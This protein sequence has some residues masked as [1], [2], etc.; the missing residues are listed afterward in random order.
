MGLRV[1]LDL[2]KVTTMR[3]LGDHHVPSPECSLCI[4]LPPSVRSVQAF[5]QHLRDSEWGGALPSK[6]LE[7]LREG[8]QLIPRSQPATALVGVRVVVELSE[9]LRIQCGCL[10]PD[11]VQ[12]SASR[13]TAGGVLGGQRADPSAAESAAH[14][15]SSL[16]PPAPGLTR[17]ERLDALDALTNAEKTELLRAGG[18]P[19][20]VQEDGKL[21]P[22]A[23]Q[24]DPK[25]N[26]MFTAERRSNII[27]QSA[28]HALSGTAAPGKHVF[29]ETQRCSSCAIKKFPVSFHNTMWDREAHQDRFC[30][31]CLERFWCRGCKKLKRPKCFSKRQRFNWR[32]GAAIEDTEEGDKAVVRHDSMRRCKVCID[33][34]EKSACTP[35][36][37]D[38]AAI[39]SKPK[40]KPKPKPM[41]MSTN[42][43]A[44]LQPIAEKPAAKDP[45]AED[46]AAEDSAAEDSAAEDSAA[47]DPPAED[48]AAEVPAA[49]DPA[50]EDPTTED[51][52][53][54]DPAAED[55]AAEDPAAK[56]SAAEE[57]AAEEP[58]AEDPTAEGPTAEDPA[59]AE[60]A[61]EEPA[62]KDPAAEDSAAEDSA[63]EDAAAEDQEDHDFGNFGFTESNLSLRPSQ[64]DLDLESVAKEEAVMADKKRRLRAARGLVAGVRALITQHDPWGVNFTAVGS[65]DRGQ[66][67]E[68]DCNLKVV[69]LDDWSGY[70]NKMVSVGPAAGGGGWLMDSCGGQ[71]WAPVRVSASNLSLKLHEGQTGIVYDVQP[72][73]DVFFVRMM[74]EI[75]ELESPVEVLWLHEESGNFVPAGFKEGHSKVVV[76]GDPCHP[77]TDSYGA[78]LVE[79]EDAEWCA[80]KIEGCFNPIWETEVMGYEFDRDVEFKEWSSFTEHW[81]EE[82]CLFSSEEGDFGCVAYMPRMPHTGGAD[83]CDY[84]LYRRRLYVRQASFFPAPVTG[85]SSDERTPAEA[86]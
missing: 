66:C 85:W 79:I 59:A 84:S 64:A 86:E 70:N 37:R 9:K 32:H 81:E 35:E 73:D 46:S 45:A 67:F 31:K 52:T 40:P 17:P 82:H 71:Q 61:A 15:P 75:P 22:A 72:R 13:N 43:F 77:Y 36:S 2:T 68:L 5:E 39:V 26:K 4:M 20:D 49:E 42:R 19:A 69:V 24:K 7:F 21:L 27:P 65:N 6:Q 47:E 80:E 30:R 57:P 38:V 55:P 54:E 33:A 12:L 50:A 53:A 62:A 56:D 23:Q 18:A 14:Q 34:A 63:A 58:A 25:H 74:S 1:E 44:A 16:A 29:Q 3:S 83:R 8:C 48:L 60:P 11:P 41:A 10:S 28:A 51:P 78:A 76:V